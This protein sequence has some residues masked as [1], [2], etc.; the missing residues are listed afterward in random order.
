MGALCFKFCCRDGLK[1]E[2]F[3]RVYRRCMLAYEAVYE[4]LLII[5]VACSY[6]APRSLCNAVNFRWLSGVGADRL[7]SGPYLVAE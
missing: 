5:H 4:G 1:R 7:S 3:I 6:L 2:L